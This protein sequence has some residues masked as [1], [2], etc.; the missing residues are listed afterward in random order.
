MDDG[1]RWPWP[2]TEK[3]NYLKKEVKNYELWRIWWT[4]CA[5]KIKRKIK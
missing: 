1:W 2:C 3:E 5:T 4:I